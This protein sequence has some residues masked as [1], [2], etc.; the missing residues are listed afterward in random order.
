VLNLNE[1][2]FHFALRNTQA[3]RIAV[4]HG[5][6]TFDAVLADERLGERFLARR[7]PQMQAQIATARHSGDRP[8]GG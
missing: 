1:R 3:R 8:A 7:L 5:I 6:E 4:T 2:I